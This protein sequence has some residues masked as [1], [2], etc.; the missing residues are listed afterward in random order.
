MR[1]SPNGRK[2]G[3]RKQNAFPATGA[4]LHCKE[5]KN[6]GANWISIKS[7]YDNQRAYRHCVLVNK[8]D[9]KLYEGITL[10]NEELLA[11]GEDVLFLE[12]LRNGQLNNI[13]AISCN[14]LNDKSCRYI[15]SIWQKYFASICLVPVKITQVLTR[16]IL[17]G[18]SQLSVLWH[19]SLFT[20]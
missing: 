12:I 5:E 13:I 11:L 18:Y 19:D 17:M 10:M 1:Q 6:C 2:A 4:C 3:H 15:N 20:G 14:L 8:E 16:S 7:D 9:E